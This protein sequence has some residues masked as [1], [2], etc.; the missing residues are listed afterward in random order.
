MNITG[1]GNI[2]LSYKHGCLLNCLGIQPVFVDNG[3]IPSS[4]LGYTYRVSTFLKP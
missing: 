1:I 2:T 3:F 4:F